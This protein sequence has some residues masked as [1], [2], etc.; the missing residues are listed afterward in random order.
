MKHRLP[1]PKS[2]KKTDKIDASDYTGADID[3]GA[4]VASQALAAAQKEKD[5]KA[6]EGHGSETGGEE[7]DQG[8]G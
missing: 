8:R 2:P 7:R 6:A 4:A 3:N 5:G 1:K